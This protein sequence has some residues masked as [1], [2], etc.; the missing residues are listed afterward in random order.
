MIIGVLT[1][2]AGGGVTGVVEGVVIKMAPELGA[3]SVPFT[4]ATLL[5][6][7]ALGIGGALFT[8][9]ILGDLFKGVAAAGA[10]VAGYVLPAMVLPDMFGARKPISGSPSV[11]QLPP[12]P[13]GAPQ[14][15]QAAA[16]KSAL[17]F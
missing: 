16:V 13:L 10:G 7:P 9:G 6:V 12:G 2:I 1:N 14:R 15:A 11:K 3:L 5:G 4:W 17:E 8:R